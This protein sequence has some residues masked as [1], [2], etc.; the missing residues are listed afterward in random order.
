MRW[1]AGMLLLLACV[2][3]AQ[4]TETLLVTA[5]TAYTPKFCADVGVE[6]K[7]KIEQW[8]RM[9]YRRP[10]PINVM[11]RDEWDRM[12]KG[13]GFMAHAAERGAAFYSPTDN[14]V[15]VVPWTIGGYLRQPDNPPKFTR[16][17]W[18][19]ILESTIIHELLH[20][21][22]YQNFYV[23]LG[24][25]SAASLKVEGLTREEKDIS[26]VDF[27]VSEGL[28]EL[29]A[30]RTGSEEAIKL[31]R[32]PEREING[33][34]IYWDRYQPDGKQPFRITLFDRGY[35]DGLDLLNQLDRKMGPRGLRAVLYRP[36]PRALF[37]NPELL[38]TVE[39]DDP[40][41][42]DSI[43]ALLSPD[44]V[45]FGELQLA[46]HPGPNRFFRRSVTGPGGARS[47]GCLVGYT[48]V[49]GDPE[50][51]HG[52]GS[53]ALYVTDPDKP[54]TWSK[55]QADSLRAKNPKKAREKSVALPRLKGVKAKLLTL[56]TADEGRWV[57]AE[58]KGMVVLAHETKPTRNLEDRVLYALRVAV[59]RAPRPRIYD[60]AMKKATERI[61][62]KLGD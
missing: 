28:A 48:A 2:G 10:V 42:P 61:S 16:E 34:Q 45:S 3:H 30:L 40:P 21:L 5:G 55:Q 9:K 54:G 18:R 58:A 53:Y 19:N 15:T 50:D 46:C 26:T 52:R 41:E 13:G 47:K 22:H 23:V 38:A 43:F 4:E 12:R 39:L 7:A 59:I 6:V 24:G 60:A 1:I 25:A 56:E 33:P 32:R 44:G 11:S 29:A 17:R 14:E 27:L 8:L 20:A 35:Q 57:R 36:P 62:T 51:K 49:V 31:T 37:F